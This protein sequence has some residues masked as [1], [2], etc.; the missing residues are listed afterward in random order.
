MRNTL[1]F[2]VLILT[3]LLC[4]A[5]YCA[6]VIDW[7]RDLQ[8]GVYRHNRVEGLLETGAQIL[9]LYLAIRF[10]RKHVDIQ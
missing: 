5:G 9:Y 8:T 4:F 10:A 2:I 1:W 3:S 7:V 6:S